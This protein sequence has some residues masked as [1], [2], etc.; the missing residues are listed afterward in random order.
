MKIGI[1]AL[2]LNKTAVP[3]FYNSQELGLGRALSEQGHDVIVYKLFS[4][5]TLSSVKKETISDTFSYVQIPASSLGINGFFKKSCLDSS[6]D[7]LVCFSDTQLYTTSV[8]SWCRKHH[9][10]FIPYIGVIN[11]SSTSRI[12]RI[13]MR[14]YRSHLLRFYKKQ[15]MVLGKTPSICKELSSLGITQA[16]LFPVGLDE[17]LLNSAYQDTSIASLKTELGYVEADEII[18]F[19]GR[20]EPEKEPLDMI[21]IFAKAYAANPNLQLCMIGKGFLEEEMKAEIKK[22]HLE[23][24]VRIV[25][26]VPND[27]MWKYYRISKCLVNLNHHEIY[28]MVLLEALYYECPVLAYRAPGPEYILSQYQT[29]SMLLDDYETLISKITSD[30]KT[31]IV[32]PSNA[33][34]SFTWS[35]IVKS[36]PNLLS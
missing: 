15:Q 31:S 23:S 25:S 8:A 22:N 9:I 27:Q 32:S 12:N 11:S 5:N 18:L 21:S 24:V 34:F 36:H 2:S 6:L 35:E 28:G 13:I 16:L 4:S 30:F 7:I 20:F 29:S 3:G 33:K 14:F 10:R 26:A 1:I 17:T 19:V